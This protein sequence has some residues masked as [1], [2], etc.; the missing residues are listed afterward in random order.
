MALK[1]LS[2]FRNKAIEVLST[3]KFKE[4]RVE[5]K[6]T[7][8]EVDKVVKNDFTVISINKQDGFSSDIRVTDNSKERCIK[9]LQFEIEML[10][11][12]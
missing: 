2:D 7:L 1:N 12:K 11:V 8:S 6:E 4:N 5:V 9:R 3:S 10:S